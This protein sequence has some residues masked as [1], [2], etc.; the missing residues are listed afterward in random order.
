LPGPSP[1]IAA[2]PGAAKHLEANPYIQRALR[3]GI[4][5]DIWGSTYSEFMG[6]GSDT[7]EGEIPDNAV[8][9]NRSFSADVTIYRCVDIRG[10]AIA[11]VPLKV[12]DDPDP[13]KRKEVDHEALGVLQATNPFGYVAG[14]ALMRY[15]LGS[16]DLHGNFA[17]RLTMDKGGRLRGPLPRE[18][19]WL[20]PAQ[21]KAV[22]GKDLDPPQPKVPFGGLKIREDQREYVI[23]PQEVVYSSTYSPVDPLRGTS[24]I[25]ALRNQLNLRLYGQM[26]NLWFLRNNQRP[27]VVVTGAFNPTVENVGLMRRI[28]RAAFGG[29]GNRGPAFLPADMNV[30]LLTM[31]A[32]DAEWLGQQH[33]AREDILAAFGVP[34]PVYGDLSRA[35]YENIRTA[36]E[37]FWRSGIIPELD[38]MAWTL[39]QQ[40][41]WKWPDAQKAKLYCCFD[42]T[43]I[44]ALQEDANAVWERTMAMLDRLLKAVE[45]KTL[46]PDQ[47]RDLARS[48]FMQ[49]GL[50]DQPWAGKVP[51]GNMFYVRLQEVP[52]IEA[53]VQA[54]IDTNAA[55]AGITGGET[56]K[57]GNGQWVLPD[58]SQVRASQARLTPPPQPPPTPPPAAPVTQSITF[59]ERLSLEVPGQAPQQL[60]PPAKVTV[61][62]HLTRL[63][64][65]ALP[66]E[67]AANGTGQPSAVPALPDAARGARDW[68]TRR[69]KRHFQDQQTA[70]L[71]RL[72]AAQDGENEADVVPDPSEL[73]DGQA[74]RESAREILEAGL[75]M[76]GQ[77]V[78]AGEL[79]DRITEDTAN[80]L[81]D[82]LLAAAE[83]GE[84]PPA[85]LLRVREVFRQSIEERA[86]E[87]AHRI[88]A[89]PAQETAA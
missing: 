13:D 20:P 80:Q 87:I 25:T 3:E 72:R 73:L 63:E 58:A 61:H 6:M 49:A 29:D 64:L 36:Y 77:Q 59:P 26:S 22:A 74:A 71:R 69:L 55:R 16:R 40:F 31:S 89:N 62:N 21:Y 7:D 56:N 45:M 19:Y 15:S 54:S 42:Y 68:I 2:S 84:A 57:P 79:A 67:P 35:T 81:A 32:K 5:K 28:W 44:E 70:A 75:A 8:G 88:I 76:A 30:H 9:R 78:D 46:I 41:L 34:P 48:L 23:P 47:F 24:K 11:S 85:V 37:G 52:V 17:W 1:F 4:F 50:P 83:D 82:A 66:G 14:P 60:P 86:S 43:A 65:P 12:Y 53:S 33:A 27:D 38:E 10:A 18:I 39:T 51:G